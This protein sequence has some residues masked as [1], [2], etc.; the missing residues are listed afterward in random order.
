M[1]TEQVARLPKPFPSK[2]L[3]SWSQTPYDY[4]KALNYSQQECQRLCFQE[5]LMYHCDCIHPAFLLDEFDHDFICNLEG[6]ANDF[7]C[8][9]DVMDDFDEGVFQCDACL[10]SCL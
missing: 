8:V 2:C 6:F 10:P 7:D 4:P 1:E 3:T 5:A 9:M